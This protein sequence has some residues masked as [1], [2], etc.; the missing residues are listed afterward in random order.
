[1][2]FW[3]ASSF[4]SPTTSFTGQARKSDQRRSAVPSWSYCTM[5]S[6]LRSYVLR[7]FMQTR[8]IPHFVH[9]RGFF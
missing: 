2:T 6:R 5:L 7:D 3:S 8:E 1:M 4:Q 9:S